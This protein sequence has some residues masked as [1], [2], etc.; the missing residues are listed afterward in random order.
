MI[1]GTDIANIGLTDFRRKLTIIPR[2]SA[3]VL[4]MLHVVYILLVMGVED[5]TIMSGTLRSALDAFQEYED[6][7]IASPIF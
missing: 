5:P 1:D 4:S 3:L 7:E 6:A 2:E